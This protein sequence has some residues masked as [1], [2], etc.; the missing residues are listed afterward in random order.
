[1][2]RN[3]LR[4]PTIWYWVTLTVA[5]ALRLYRLADWDL[6]TDEVQTLWTAASGQFKEG[7]MYLTAPLNFLLT[8]LGVA[9]LGENALGARVIPFLAGTLTV[10]VIYPIWRPWVGRRAALFAT[11]TLGLSMWHVFWSQTARHFAVETLLIVLAVGGFLRY[12]HR[13]SRSALALA[14]LF[15][16]AALLTHSSA[17]FYI[18]AV[19]CFVGAMLLRPARGTGDPTPDE[20]SRRAWIAGATL[21]GVLG[22]YVPVYLTV[23]RY[24]LE[25]KTPWN[26]PWNILGSLVFYIPPYL[27]IFALAGVAFLIRERNRVWLLALCLTAIPPLLLI[28]ASPFTITSAAYCLASMLAVAI[29][30]GVAAD[31]L[32]AFGAEHASIGPA[33]LILATAPISQLYDL[34]AYYT[35]FHGLKPHWRAVSAFVAERRQPGEMFLAAE[36]DVVQYYLGRLNADWLGPFERSLGKPGYPPAGVCGVW[37]AVYPSSG[38]L[39]MDAAA[40]AYIAQNA[41]LVASFPLH[42]GAKD[43]TISVFHQPVGGTE[44]SQGCR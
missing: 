14:A 17:G 6:W 18:V 21:L 8:R 39:A 33:A 40:T 36:G 28:S 43:R 44:P 22:L 10:A 13:G 24:L 20:L 2:T 27:A 11:V 4:E 37:Y 3:R 7:P 30:V 1:M 38:P 41:R 31:R 32:L 26:P 29:L 42:Y 19:L 35:V 16:L 34:A 15:F 12:W 25:H 9:V 23:G 5:I